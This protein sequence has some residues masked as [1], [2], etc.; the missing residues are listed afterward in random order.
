MQSISLRVA[1]IL[2]LSTFLGACAARQSA[3][4]PPPQPAVAAEPVPSGSPLARIQ[5]G[6]TY[7]DV[8]NILGPP[9][10]QIVYPSGKAWI[11][12]Y[13]GNDIMRS[14]YFY[15][16]LGRITFA[17]GNQ[18][19]AGRAGAVEKVEYDPNETGIAR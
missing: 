10:T 11:P 12:Y 16:G 6:M 5:T 7:E 4:E 9:T 3:P 14:A 18:F 1:A 2:A 15:K 8:T 19:G 13:Y 17:S